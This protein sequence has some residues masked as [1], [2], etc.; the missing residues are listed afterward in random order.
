MEILRWLVLIIDSNA[1]NAEVV[2]RK[3]KEAPGRVVCHLRS[4]LVLHFEAELSKL[5]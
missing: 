5:K 3:S 2:V 4:S 1:S